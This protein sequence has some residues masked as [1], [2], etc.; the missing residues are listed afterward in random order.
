[1]NSAKTGDEDRDYWKDLSSNMK[2][3]FTRGYSGRWDQGCRVRHEEPSWYFSFVGSWKVFD[4]WK[5]ARDEQ[6]D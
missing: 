6:T 5:F 1:M 2:K 4:E 3:K